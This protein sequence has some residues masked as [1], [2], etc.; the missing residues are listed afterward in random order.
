MCWLKV[1]YFATICHLVFL[2]VILCNFCFD[3]ETDEI[4][5]Q[6]AKMTKVS[7]IYTDLCSV[8]CHRFAAV[9]TDYG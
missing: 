6:N 8:W 1:A 9:D 5:S 7:A 2:S 3:N 4:T